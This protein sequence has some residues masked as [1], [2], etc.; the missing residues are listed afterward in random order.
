MDA[1]NGCGVALSDATASRRLIML[2]PNGGCIL[3]ERRNAPRHFDTGGRLQATLLPN[4]APVPVVIHDISDHG[5][6]L[7]TPDGIAVGSHLTIEMY[8]P[9]L[10][11][12]YMRQ[13]CV[14]H[15]EQREDGRWLVGGQF[16]ARLTESEVQELL[17]KNAE[18]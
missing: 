15:T 1:D 16:S 3:T 6:G 2:Q 9:I 14:L 13:L 18:A 11:C 7:I 10:K 12:W 8:H 17:R 5:L 4:H